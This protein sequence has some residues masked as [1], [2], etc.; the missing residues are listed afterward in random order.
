MMFCC[1]A[2]LWGGFRIRISNLCIKS[3]GKGLFG[4]KRC[5]RG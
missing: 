5:R 1:H 4:E 2:V 3:A